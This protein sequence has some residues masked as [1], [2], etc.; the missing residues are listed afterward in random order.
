MRRTRRGRWR[1]GLTVLGGAGAHVAEPEFRSRG[2]DQPVRRRAAARL[3]G[4]CA[5]DRS[6]GASPIRSWA[7]ISFATPFVYASFL[8]N[9]WIG[10]RLRQTE[11]PALIGGAAVFGSMQF[12]LLTNFGTWLRAARCIRTRWRAVRPASPRRF[13]S[14][15]TR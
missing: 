1:S 7:A 15:A 10:S 5:A 3:A 2:R 8:I 14:S 9:V 6:D 12:F 11:N 4:V 13:R